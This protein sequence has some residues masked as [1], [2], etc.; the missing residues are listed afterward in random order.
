M[1]FAMRMSYSEYLVMD[2]ATFAKLTEVLN[3]SEIRH[4]NGY[5]A[6]TLYTPCIAEVSIFTIKEDQLVDSLPTVE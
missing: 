4:Q 2:Q 6:E 1:K 5:G 3:K